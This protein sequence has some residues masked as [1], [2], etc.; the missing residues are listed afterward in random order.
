MTD[1]KRKA[2]KREVSWNNLSN[3]LDGGLLCGGRGLGWGRLFAAGEVCNLLRF[4]RTAS[5][6]E[7]WRNV[8]W[9][10]EGVWEQKKK[11]K[12]WGA[13][14]GA[15]GE[16]SKVQKLEILRLRNQCALEA[17]I[18][19][20]MNYDSGEVG[21]FTC[22]VLYII[23]HTDFFIFFLFVLL[24]FFR[25]GIVVRTVGVSYLQMCGRLL[26]FLCSRLQQCITIHFQLVITNY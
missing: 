9:R 21:G 20:V 2:Q 7:W 14:R 6:D 25:I 3:S 16:Q 4:A 1:E 22:N 10:W 5:H 8:G 24:C 23:R 26:L 19:F 13:C 17:N 12:G 18:G 11:K 15:R